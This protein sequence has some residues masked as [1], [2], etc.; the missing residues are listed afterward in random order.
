MTS[1]HTMASLLMHAAL[2]QVSPQLQTIDKIIS[3]PR[4]PAHPLK[5]TLPLELLLLIRRQLL[6]TLTDHLIAQSDQALFKY[7]DSIRSLLCD[8]C[9]DWNEE[10]YGRSVWHWQRPLGPCWCNSTMGLIG[11]SGD[12]EVDVPEVEWFRD[13]LHW[14]ESHLSKS[15]CVPTTSDADIWHLV[16]D[17][18]REY[19]CQ[20][21]R[22]SETKPK[23]LLSTFRWPWN[24]SQPLNDRVSL[25]PS[26]SGP[27]ER[28]TT[29][30]SLAGSGHDR[31][32]HKVILRCVERD[33]GIPLFSSVDLSSMPS[34]TL[35]WD[36]QF[37][38]SHESPELDPTMVKGA[39][40]SLLTPRDAVYIAGILVLKQCLDDVKSQYPLVVMVTPDVPSETR[41]LLSRRGLVLTQIDYLQPSGDATANK[42]DIRFADTWT[43]LRAFDLFDYEVK[44]LRG[45]FRVVL[46]DSDMIIKR[47][48]DELMTLDIPS[49]WIAAGH[50]C[51]CNP[52]K[53]A[54]YPKDWI[55]ENCGFTPV[56]S[57][58]SPP[59]EITADSPRPHGLLNSGLVVLN[60]SPEISQ[61][62]S[63][64]LATSPDVPTFSFP[65]QDLLAA[66][67]KGK[68]KPLNWYYN[69]LK[70]L[71]A[72]GTAKPSVATQCLDN[73]DPTKDIEYQEQI[74]RE[75]IANFYA[76]GSDT[77]VSALNTFF[78]AM[79][80]HHEV[81]INAQKELD[82]VLGGRLP[83]F[84]DEASLPYISA[85]VKE[86][87]R[88]EPVTPIAIPHLVTEDDVY[89]GYRIPANSMV[90]GNAWAILHDETMY[91]EPFSFKP[92]RW[93]TPEGRLNPDI[94]DPTVI[95]GFGRRICPGRHIATSTLWIAA[96][97]ILTTFNITKAK[98]PAGNII[99]PDGKYH[100]AMICH[101]LPFKCTIKPRS[102]SA[103][104]L[105]LSIPLQ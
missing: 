68:W 49:G 1:S 7:E 8:E 22:D 103:E 66:Y 37:T 2:A 58:T 26:S 3:Q 12:D 70:T 101:A 9:L 31:R 64:Y 76:A 53:F 56:K 48:M 104:Q 16:C 91:P 28:Q 105:I 43:K 21:V 95:F 79:L 32:C 84:D 83:E 29:I 15:P 5:P 63:H 55:P 72:K 6:L 88:W 24:D 98:D 69:A 73:V 90:V 75:T 59:P 71:R 46:L 39:W 92:D 85:I 25:I 44:I 10:V 54:H 34:L 50:A 45:F 51:A 18:L 86:V 36:A 99:E 19:Q 14:L 62:L 4:T 42:V 97:S 40:A 17:I 100:S 78:L 13:P 74:I 93:L 38:F 81:Q 20:V 77:T 82:E 60:P 57:P 96:A 89:R 35:P 47:N 11:G 87:L 61:G 52:R 30:C 41:S 33:L 80:R 94:R 65:D 102:K 27:G 23:P 67:F